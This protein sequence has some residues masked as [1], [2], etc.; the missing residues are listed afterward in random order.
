MVICKATPGN[1][2]NLRTYLKV[3]P[4]PY[5]LQIEHSYSFIPL[6]HQKNKKI[7]KISNNILNY[8]DLIMYKAEKF[9]IIYIRLSLYILLFFYLS[10]HLPINPLLCFIK[11]LSS[12]YPVSIE[13]CYKID[14]R[15]ISTK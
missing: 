11:T 8:M 13:K 12:Y 1:S 4:Y 9:Y 6:V 5:S 15:E 2:Y 14:G 3:L 7:K 10:I